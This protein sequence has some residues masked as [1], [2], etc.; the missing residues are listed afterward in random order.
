[1][2]LEAVNSEKKDLEKNLQVKHEEL[3]K[4][5]ANLSTEVECYER[6]ILNLEEES[7]KKIATLHEEVSLYL[8]FIMFFFTSLRW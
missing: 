5:K 4:I 8:T 6:K 7:K 1:M 3:L 2:K